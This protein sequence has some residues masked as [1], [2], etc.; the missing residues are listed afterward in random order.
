MTR[1]KAYTVIV[2]KKIGV[3][4]RWTDVAPLIHGV[5]EPVYQGFKDWDSAQEAFHDALQRGQTRIVS[6]GPSSSLRQ[7]QEP[8]STRTSA[9]TRTSPRTMSSAARARRDAIIAQALEELKQERESGSA[10]TEQR[11][12]GGPPSTNLAV[13]GG[14]RPTLPAANMPPGSAT[15]DVQKAAS[16]TTA[17]SVSTS[18]SPPTGVTQVE[19][20]SDSVRSPRYAQSLSYSSD[21]SPPPATGSSA[22]ASSDWRSDVSSPSTGQ[23]R[24]FP[25]DFATRPRDRFTKAK[26]GGPA[27]PLPLGIQ[28]PA[29]T[30]SK[31]A[32][33][34][35]STRSPP[36]S[37]SLSP[38]TTA[39]GSEPVS[40]PPAPPISRRRKAGKSYSD[41]AIQV[42]RPTR[43]RAYVD[44]PVQAG[45]NK[46]HATAETQTSSTP[47][48]DARGLCE[49]AHPELPARIMQS[50]PAHAS[51]EPALRSS[52]A[53]PVSRSHTT[54]PITR[55]S[56]SSPTSRS[57]LSPTSRASAASPKTVAFSSPMATPPPDS[58]TPS[59]SSASPASY[60]SARSATSD[61]RRSE[62][63][64]F[65]T[66][67]SEASPRGTSIPAGSESAS[68]VRPS[69][70][71]LPLNSLLFS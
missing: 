57:M 13:Q 65:E 55:S 2:G 68:L 47:E 60:R 64:A 21:A 49:C 29:K 18:S 1:A 61:E 24:H 16:T 33:P 54:F 48:G 19:H 40:S 59:S 5:S 9:K 4:T 50:S 66:A 45:Q 46:R 36:S 10:R 43:K 20:G 6:V 41:A 15:G 23:T 52:M 27:L 26:S 53:S 58:P 71:M 28:S 14:V 34:S 7:K 12:A 11:G 42:E 35:S 62:A 70:V 44:A 17:S 37:L 31:Y 56:M 51:A 32:T 38:A 25:A 3:F 30:V 67:R 8:A 63:A 39:S 22:L 69:P